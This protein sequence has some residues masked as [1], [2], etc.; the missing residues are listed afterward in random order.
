MPLV[1]LVPKVPEHGV[2]LH[3]GGVE[4]SE[5]SAILAALTAASDS[6]MGAGRVCVLFGNGARPKSA[7]SPWRD[8]PGAEIL[9]DGPLLPVWAYP[10]T[11]IVAAHAGFV[12]LTRVDLLTPLFRNLSTQAMAD[13]YSFGSALLPEVESHVLRAKWL[14]KGDIATILVR[15]PAHFWFS[16]DGDNIDAETGLWARISH[17]PECPADLRATASAGTRR[18]PRSQ[19]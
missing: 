3:E 11:C 15:D 19:A 10:L 8:V 17:G 9:W 7:Y 1:E 18:D 6:L 2:S 14:R 5:V 16:L 13:L 12:R 4:E